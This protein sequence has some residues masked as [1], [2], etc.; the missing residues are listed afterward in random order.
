MDSPSRVGHSR[1][2]RLLWLMEETERGPGTCPRHSRP[3]SSVPGEE[4]HVREVAPALLVAPCWPANPTCRPR[5]AEALGGAVRE[6]RV[7]GHRPG[8]DRWTDR[9]RRR[10][11]RHGTLLRPALP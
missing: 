1:P 2:R 9:H 3:Y 5:P 6:A 11:F 10:A 7:A 8:S 4:N